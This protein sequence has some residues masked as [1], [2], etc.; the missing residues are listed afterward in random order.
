MPRA[1]RS[2]VTH[3]TTPSPSGSSVQGEGGGIRLG[4]KF[5]TLLA[6]D[7]AGRC[8]TIGHA[9]MCFTSY[10]GPHS[11]G[12]RS[13]QGPAMKGKERQRKKMAHFPWPN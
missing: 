12:T 4:T 13:A 10:L 9:N 7:P 11:T 3:C 2:G 8:I 1:R 5:G 6:L